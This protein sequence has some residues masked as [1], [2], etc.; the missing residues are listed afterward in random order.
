MTSQSV[1]VSIMLGEETRLV[2][3]LWY[4]HRQGRESASFEYDQN[5]LRYSKRFALEPS[6]YIVG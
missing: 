6:F 3:R 1:F 2:G 5:W 4:Y